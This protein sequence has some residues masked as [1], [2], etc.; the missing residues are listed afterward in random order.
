MNPPCPASP[1][2]RDQEL[3][4]IQL[5]VARRADALSRR[6]GR[7]SPAR[8]R[9]VWLRAEWEVFDVREGAENSAARCPRRRVAVTQS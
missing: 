5:E 7:G 8:D 3:T 4:V 6:E 1:E 9:R 2:L